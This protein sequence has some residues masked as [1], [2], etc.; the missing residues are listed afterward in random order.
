MQIETEIAQKIALLH[1]RRRGGREGGYVV[2]P[3]GGHELP[4]E[5]CLS[6]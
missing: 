2:V 6:L 5:A 4:I 3:G 1:R